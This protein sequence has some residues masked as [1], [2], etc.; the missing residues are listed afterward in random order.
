MTDCYSYRSGTAPLLIS[1][2]HDGRELPT[3]IAARMTSAGLAIPDTDWHVRQLYEF[4]EALDANVIAANFSRYVV[5]LNRASDDTAL[6]KDQL[7]TGLCPGNTFAGE[8]IYKPGQAVSRD[9]QLSRI[10]TY[11]KPYHDQLKLA[12]TELRE[13]HGNVLLWDAHS[14]AAEVPLLFEGRLPDL[15]I[16][17]DDGRSCDQAIADTAAEVAGQSPYSS[18]LNG[19]FRG[20]F[21]TRHYGEP[22]DGVHA[23]QLE[24]A[25][26]CYMNESSLQFDDRLAESLTYT[27]QKMLQACLARAA[28]TGITSQ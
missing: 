4:A 20:G 15:N 7:A 3:D 17:T 28:K 16:G 22:A 10:A 8:D 19:R 27:I 14:I 11:W 13:E 25:Q 12:L 1:V 18:V 21:I 2:P 5:D 26:C 23:L 6:Y 24:L 9:E